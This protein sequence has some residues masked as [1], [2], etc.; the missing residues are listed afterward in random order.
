MQNDE[1]HIDNTSL[2]ANK[3]KGN[4]VYN[5]VEDALAISNDQLLANWSRLA[6]FIRI[7]KG[8][9]K[10]A[11]AE[12]IALS[13][14]KDKIKAID[15]ITK[16]RAEHESSKEAKQS[17]EKSNKKTKTAK[18]SKVKTPKPRPPQP[19]SVNYKRLMQVASDLEIRLLKGTEASGK[20][21]VA[22]LMDFN[23][24]FI[25]KESEGL[26]HLAISHNYV[27]NGDLIPDPDMQILVDVENQ[28]VQALAIQHS[29]GRYAKV[30]DN[31]FKRNIVDLAEKKDQNEFLRVWLNNVV[32]QGHKIK[33]HD[34]EI[35]SK[36]SLKEIKSIKAETEKEDS[37]I[38]WKTLAG[39]I[40]DGEGISQKDAEE[41]ARELKRSG[42][43]EVYLSEIN[44]KLQESSNKELRAKLVNI[45][46]TNY[47]MLLRLI[48]DILKKSKDNAI[49]GQ[50]SVKDG[51][52]KI[53]YELIPAESKDKGKFLFAINEKV[54]SN[55]TLIVAVHPKAKKSWAILRTE[56]FAE[57]SDYDLGKY[58][59][60][61]ETQVKVSKEYAEW[62]DILIDLDYKITWRDIT[63]VEDS[64][65]N[66]PQHS[67]NEKTKPK[68]SKRKYKAGEVQLDD[69]LKEA[70]LTKRDINWINKHKQGM[71]LFPTNKGVFNTKD[72]LK[73]AEKT[74]LPR[75]KRVSRY[76]NVYYE[77]RTN[78][79]DDPIT[80]V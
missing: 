46:K 14:F 24:D 53:V 48:P 38:H 21:K 65:Q 3:P 79:S 25:E 15:Y 77:T 76:G 75:G 69:E 63:E 56:G 40:R 10:R 72:V 59:N 45:H 58:S 2:E 66:E 41:K 7:L 35:E 22:G 51:S 71:I 34:S 73:D 44:K 23:M 4:R 68:K 52:N 6:T 13:L 12:K 29:T 47:Q 61:L 50:L 11:E 70:G 16:L 9:K 80:G 8:F 39:L 32:N 64:K 20:S 74:A 33:W 37:T 28:L 26:Y 60:D 19:Y 17:K 57:K 31:P 42:K 55:E 1:K 30:Y 5:T 62:L 54:G 67:K 27:Q 18:K 43:E 49:D 36:P 78:R